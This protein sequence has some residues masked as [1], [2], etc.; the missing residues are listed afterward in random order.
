MFGE[1]EGNGSALDRVE[2]EIVRRELSRSGAVLLK[3]FEV[4]LSSF[5]KFTARFGESR[6]AI[7]AVA[8]GANAGINPHSEAHF[9]P[10]CPDLLFFFCARPARDGGRTTVCDG[11]DLY[12][13]LTGRTRKKLKAAELCWRVELKKQWFEDALALPF[14]AIRRR[15]F[16]TMPSCTFSDTGDAVRYELRNGPMKDTMLGPAV[17]NGLLATMDY[18]SVDLEKAQKIA[19]SLDR[20]AL[21]EIMDAAY[22]VSEAIEWEAGDVFVIDNAR[23]MHGREPFADRERMIHRRMVW[24]PT[25]H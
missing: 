16:D 1:I 2:S 7:P 18:R 20:H 8:N 21:W 23:A 4:D 6:G 14:D 22:E 9:S 11:V 13:A 17:V 3:G 12:R 24:R 25:L 5:E 15:W 19:P 10:L